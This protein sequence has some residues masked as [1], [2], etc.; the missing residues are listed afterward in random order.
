[1]RR[2]ERISFSRARRTPTFSRPVCFDEAV[3]IR[4]VVCAAR[5][6][7]YGVNTPHF[8][9]TAEAKISVVFAWAI[10][11][12]TKHHA[13]PA[14][15]SRLFLFSKASFAEALIFTGRGCISHVCRNGGCVGT[16]ELMTCCMHR[17]S[18]PSPVIK[19]TLAEKARLP[20]TVHGCETHVSY[21]LVSRIF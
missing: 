6:L 14:A 1:M 10:M 18:R 11:R 2:V 17:K 15:I 16:T 19:W 8:Q 7:K 4:V 9:S 12:D 20:C 3:M 21:L 5:S 13:M